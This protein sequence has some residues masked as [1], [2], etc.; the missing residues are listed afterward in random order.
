[1]SSE[2]KMYPVMG[3]HNPF[4]G[5]WIEFADVLIESERFA[6]NVLKHIPAKKIAGKKARGLCRPSRVNSKNKGE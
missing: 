6:K 2:K 3:M 4:N 5:L 1:M